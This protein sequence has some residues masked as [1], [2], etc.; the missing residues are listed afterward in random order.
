MNRL[1]VFA[2]GLALSLLTALT[3]R[4]DVEFFLQITERGR[5]TVVV[6]EQSVTLNHGRFRFFDL[7]PGRSRVVVL[8]NNLPVFQD[9]LELRPDSRTVAEFNPRRGMRL[10]AQFPLYDNGLYCG[11]DWN[12]PGWTNRAG[13]GRPGGN[14]ANGRPGDAD[15][16]PRHEG[17]FRPFEM[18]PR[19][20]DRLRMG[21][22]RE[23]FDDRR[24]ELLRNVLPGQPISTAQV[25]ELLRLFSFDRYRLEA[26]KVGWECVT[27]RASYYAAFDT[28]AFESS[29]AELKRHIGW[30]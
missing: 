2:F 8:R 10:V 12:P 6:D 22:S 27:D 3:A 11:P 24:F 29:R 7:P 28:F 23:S 5:Y 14:W 1:P 20:F 19:E 15:N 9:W 17:G 4:A 25:C 18:N 21:L 16:R 13:V 26:A 30:R